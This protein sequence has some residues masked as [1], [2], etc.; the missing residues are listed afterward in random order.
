V[1]LCVYVYVCVCIALLCICVRV[2]VC[3]CVHYVTAMI[4]EQLNL[5][6]VKVENFVRTV[7]V[8]K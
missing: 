3:A 8:V 6:K 7:G 4:I 1:C 2:C 5:V